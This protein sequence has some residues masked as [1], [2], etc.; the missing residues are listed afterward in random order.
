MY[1]KAVPHLC[2]PTAEAL[3]LSLLPLHPSVHPRQQAA[4]VDRLSTDATVL[5]ISDKW[6]QSRCA[7]CDWPL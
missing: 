3:L 2:A 7:L 1:S 6:N 4:S 5:G